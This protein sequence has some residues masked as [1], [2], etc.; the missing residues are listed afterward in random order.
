[1]NTLLCFDFICT[2]P[3]PF[4]QHLC[5]LLLR[6]HPLTTLQSND[7]FTETAQISI[8]NGYLNNGHYRYRIEAQGTQIQLETLADRIAKDFLL[9]VHLVKAKIAPLEKSQGSTSI[10]ILKSTELPS[11]QKKRLFSK[12]DA[13]NS[14]L[15]EL[16]HLDY[17][18]TCT[19]LF[20]DNQSPKFAQI[21]LICP[22]CHGEE[23][24]KIHKEALLTKQDGIKRSP[25]LTTLTQERLF[26]L[27][28]ELL[29]EHTVKIEELGVTLSTQIALFE[30]SE[31]LRPQILICNPNTLNLF[32]NTTSEQVI[33]LSCFEKPAITLTTKDAIQIHSSSSKINAASCDVRFAYNRALIIVTEYLRQKGIDFLYYRVNTP[34]AHMAFIDQHWIWLQQPYSIAL[35]TTRDTLHDNAVVGNYQAIELKKKVI[36]HNSVSLV[37]PVKSQDQAFNALYAT[38]FSHASIN[39]QD[40]V[41]IFLSRNSLSQ[42]ITSNRLRDNGKIEKDKAESI[43]QF[44][45]LPNNGIDFIQQ[46]RAS[47]KSNIE[48]NLLTSVSIIDKFQLAYPSQYHALSTMKL[49]NQSQNLTS[50]LVVAATLLGLSEESSLSEQQS[51]Q[52]AV[53]RLLTFAGYF[54]T[55]H[56]PHIDFPK[57]V[58]EKSTLG[59]A[60]SSFDWCQTFKSLMSFC[61]AKKSLKPTD[62]DE[63]N[64]HTARLAFGFLDSLAE[65]MSQWI[66]TAG[67]RVGITNVL[68]AGDEF[69]YTLFT[70][71]LCRRLKNNYLIHAS[72]H[73]DLEGANLVAGALYLPRR[74]TYP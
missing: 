34:I 12:N 58:L 42:I 72:W 47:I 6:A 63:E 45:K 43:L 48:G 21:D 2:Q 51:N 3:V 22:C 27:A 44:P 37:L 49:S 17:C 54:P 38:Q 23:H 61:L 20:G 7:I 1:M 62:K 29:S 56:S 25:S 68:L 41:T 50:L 9:S 65:E 33:T 66:E 70:R 74:R 11:T 36:I 71:R 53:D 55:E 32:F 39:K 67:H 69:Q 16:I 31:Q 26:S 40:I 35:N 59:S 10:Q 13:I 18:A 64:S 19:P 46:L 73:L 30:H 15:Y 4:Y 60:P 28:K 24:Y 14:P 57:N 5:N 8:D 52:Q